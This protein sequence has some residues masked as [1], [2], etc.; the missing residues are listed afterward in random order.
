MNFRYFIHSP[1]RFLYGILIATSRLWPDELYLKAY[2]YVTHGKKLNLKNPKTFNDK[3]NWMKLHYHDELFKKLADKY[4]VKAYVSKVIGEKYLVPN[5]GVWNCFDDIDFSEL[6]EKFVLKGTHD[7]G[8]AFICKDK[9]SFEF[10]RVKKQLTKNL[11][12]NYYFPRREWVYKDPNPRIIAD[13]LLD[14]GTGQELKDYKFWCFNGEPRVM[15]ITNK[16][17]NIEENFY[18]MDFNVLDINHG[19]PRT[20]PEYIRPQNFELM[21]YLATKL[22]QNIPFVRIDFFNIKGQVFFGEFTFYDWAGLQPFTDDDWD[23]KLGSW[24]HL[25]NVN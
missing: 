1:R 25:S 10:E 9:K 4:E 18:D 19:F 16:G 2:Y 11:A 13:K 8:G 21:K 5:Y 24:I 6:P 7:S 14:E 20:T 12:R 17:K 22:S 3:L 23:L 15:Y